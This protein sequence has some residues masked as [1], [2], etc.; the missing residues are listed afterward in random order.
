MP[1]TGG[2]LKA[3][4]PQDTAKAVQ[5]SFA[6]DEPRRESVSEI[7]PP[8]VRDLCSTAGIREAL[9]HVEVPRT[10]KLAE[11]VW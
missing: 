1:I 9:L 8:K 10:V 2:H 6:L 3:G 11:K 4:V 7:V 5:V